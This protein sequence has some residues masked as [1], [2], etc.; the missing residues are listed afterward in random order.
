MKEKTFTLIELLV[1]MAI[2]AILAAMLLPALA[3]AQGS[4]R[5][6]SCQSN[7]KQL[8]YNFLQYGDDNNGEGPIYDMDTSCNYQNIYSSKYLSGYVIPA[9]FAPASG[10][11]FFKGA[12]ICP[13][14]K[15]VVYTGQVA[16][17][18][19]STRIYSAYVLAYGTAIPGRTGSTWFGW[20]NAT[21]TT[22][23]ALCVPNIKYLGRT[24]TAPQGHTA[25]LRK[26]SSHP[27]VG[28]KAS[29]NTATALNQHDYGYNN[30]FFDGHVTYSALT[31]L[32]S[33]LNTNTANTLRWAN[34]ENTK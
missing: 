34:P 13:G 14:V 8:A 27:M 3:K 33:S 4:A 12:I 2:I 20:Y 32:S 28:D 15:G 9:G 22:A 29:V 18:V 16:G 21:A 11:R 1:V 19:T 10:T 5:R 25:S 31:Q 7:L 26:P 23:T 24:I 6:A 30:A 17:N